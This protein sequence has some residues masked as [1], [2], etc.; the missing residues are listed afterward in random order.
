M[1]ARISCAF[2]LLAMVIAMAV[3]IAVLWPEALL[4]FG[5]VA[6]LFAMGQAVMILRCWRKVEQGTALIITGG[7]EPTVH[8][9]KAI[10]LPLIRRE[11]N[12]DISVKRIDIFRHGSEGLVCKDDVRA[13]IKVAFHVRVNNTAEDVL[14]V[15]QTVGTARAADPKQLI[16]RF[17]AR[18]SES[19]RTVV[20]QFDYDELL[21]SPEAF[22]NQILNVIGGD[23]NGYVLD[24]VAIDYLERSP[25]E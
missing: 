8:F 10:V 14:K 13:D 21:T 25:V 17:G 19:M 9:S 11:E 5:F 22:K 24:D 12:M 2:V 6:S 15:A 1:G 7:I 20:K 4:A 3:G 23:L 18:F 16:E